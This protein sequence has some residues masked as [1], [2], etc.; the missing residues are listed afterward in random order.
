[1]QPAESV[2]SPCLACH[3]R[4][5]F[6]GVETTSLHPEMAYPRISAQA[7]AR[8]FF[9]IRVSFRPTHQLAGSF[10]W[11]RMVSFVFWADGNSPSAAS[12]HTRATGTVLE[13]NPSAPMAARARCPTCAAPSAAVSRLRPRSRRGGTPLRPESVK[14]RRF[15]TF[16]CIMSFDEICDGE[17]FNHMHHYSGQK[18]STKYSKRRQAP[19]NRETGEEKQ[20][21]VC[22]GA[23]RHG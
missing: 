2:P 20:S 19:G 22:C 9:L 14:G 4:D 15:V 17:V 23:N 3:S 12:R 13:L 7:L 1:M 8:F 5:H 21:D 10:F 16:F 11:M 6:R 18:Y